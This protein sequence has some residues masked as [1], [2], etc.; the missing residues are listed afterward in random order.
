MNTS[1]QLIGFVAIIE[2]A[3]VMLFPGR[4]VAFGFIDALN[5]G[6]PLPCTVPKCLALGGAMT[7]GVDDAYSL[8]LNPAGIPGFGAEAISLGMN[9]GRWTETTPVG[10]TFISRGEDIPF[11]LYGAGSFGIT[12]KLSASAGC[13]MVSC[14]D[15]TGINFIYSIPHFP[16]SVTT[17]QH[18]KSNGYLH[19][20]LAGLSYSL[21]DNLSIGVSGGMRFGS[22]DINMTEFEYTSDSTVTTD[23]DLSWSE[24]QFCWHGGIRAG[25]GFGNAGLAIT[26]PTDHY[27]TRTAIGAMILAEHLMN[28]KI[29]FECEIVSPS[30]DAEYIGRLIMETPTASFLNTLVGISFTDG[31]N[32]Y[33]SNLGFS[34][35]F[36]MIFD[37]VETQFGY[38]YRNRS[39]RSL[40]D[41]DQYY[42]YFDDS[43][44]LFSAVVFYML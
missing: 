5:Q 42:E 37:T 39:R 6:T 21:S 10:N 18:L 26:S 19:E 7:V 9:F 16:D 13:C 3:C 43:T 17:S 40:P 30:K 12:D 24:N 33:N 36:E 11:S 29:G 35:G 8:F 23:H 15:Y 1:K 25:F 38:F 44:S 41:N 2:I 14:F 27:P 22:A 31:P 28:L 4:S 20:A 32:C 34:I